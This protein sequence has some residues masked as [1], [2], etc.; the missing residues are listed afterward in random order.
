MTLM[1][2][3]FCLW[4]AGDLVDVEL[5]HETTP[6][7]LRSWDA[8]AAPLDAKATHFGFALEATELVLEG[9]ATYSVRRGMYFEVP[10]AG[11]LEG[12]RGILISQP[13]YRGLFQLGGPIEKRGRLLYIDGCSDTLLISPVVRGEA[14][15]NLLYLPPS[16][17]QTTHTHPSFRAGVIVAGKGT[18]R[19]GAGDT[20]LT[21][22]DVFAIDAEGLHSFHTDLEPLVVIA[23]HPD[24][25]FGPWHDD[26]PMV[27]RTMIDGHSAASLSAEER[28]VRPLD[29]ACASRESPPNRDT[30]SNETLSRERRP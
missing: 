23:F 14:C 20:A 21:P 11:R 27:N 2:S 4:P 17:R 16:T 8:T 24:S 28:R 18:C 25:D 30:S 22:G 10:G 15:L 26:H 19:T 5:R 1:K 6:F 13:E 12:G 7:R 3:S 9:G 29:P